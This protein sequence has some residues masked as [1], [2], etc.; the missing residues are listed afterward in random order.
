LGLDAGDTRLFYT[1]AEKPKGVLV[2]LIE[3]LFGR[4]GHPPLYAGGSRKT[5]CFKDLIIPI[6]GERSQDFINPYQV[7]QRPERCFGA[8]LI[9]GF[10]SFMLDSFGV[11]QEP[12]PGRMR[13]AMVTRARSKVHPGRFQRH[14]VN[15]PE[16]MQALEDAKQTGHLTSNKAYLWEK[17]FNGEPMSRRRAPVG[18][19]KRS[20][21]RTESLQATD[22]EAVVDSEAGLENQMGMLSHA[23][24]QVW[25]VKDL[26]PE[27]MSIAQQLQTFANTDLL[28][29]PHGAGLTWSI[30]LPTCGQ[31]LE[32]CTANLLHYVHLVRYAGRNHTCRTGAERWE[33]IKFFIDIKAEIDVVRSLEDQWR[34]C[35]QKPMA[36]API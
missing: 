27:D 34:T 26:R 36:L 15:Q 3:Q 33:S 35:Q 7:D 29:S 11:K 32:F 31:V 13:I 23:L 12:S 4:A 30:L 19:L 21:F 16:F 20:L 17:T 24:S 14:M 22:S 6:P 8:P 18:S 28:I 5:R 2:P 10:S 1:S 25:E 9:R